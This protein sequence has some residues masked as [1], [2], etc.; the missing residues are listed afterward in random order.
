M[1]DGGK[2]DCMLGAVG[3]FMAN[4]GLCGGKS[5]VAENMDGIA[6]SICI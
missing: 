2:G 6:D 1:V 5:S 4:T 3:P